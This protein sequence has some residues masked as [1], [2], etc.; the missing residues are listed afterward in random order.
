MQQVMEL[1]RDG[2]QVDAEAR[3]PRTGGRMDEVA[4]RRR[5][6]IW[7]DFINA[8]LDARGMRPAQLAVY[9]N[10]NAST[11][12][13]WR[14][15]KSLP[16]REAVHGVARCFRLPVEVV[17]EKAGMLPAQQRLPGRIDTD[18]E[19]RALLIDIDRLPP[20]QFNAIKSA[21]KLALG[22]RRMR[23]AG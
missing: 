17:A 5:L 14:H 1:P 6:D 12:S 21:L 9:A 2:G 22:A 23:R 7:A 10:V 8:E 18:A 3:R 11:V 20:E 16:D 15:R 13:V 4:R 19:W